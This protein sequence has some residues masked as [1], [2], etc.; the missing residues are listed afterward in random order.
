MNL[1]N[2]WKKKLTMKSWLR[3]AEN[4]SGLCNH[5]EAREGINTHANEG[6]ESNR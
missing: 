2:N 1:E 5:I 6:K 4:Y 3:I